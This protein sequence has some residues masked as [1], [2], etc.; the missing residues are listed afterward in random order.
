MSTLEAVPLTAVPPTSEISSEVQSFTVQPTPA[1]LTVQPAPTTEVDVLVKFSTGFKSFN[2]S[3]TPEVKAAAIKLKLAFNVR[4][5]KGGTHL[6]VNGEEM[7][8]KKFVDKYF[9]ITPKRFNQI[10]D[11]EEKKDTPLPPPPDPAKDNVA[12]DGNKFEELDQQLHAAL[13]ELERMKAD[14][15]ALVVERWSDLEPDR[16]QVELTKIIEAL[17]LGG[18]LRVEIE[19]DVQ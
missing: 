7:D 1:K 9:G 4:Q 12:L 18:Y 6:L 2:Q 11:L 16:V 19:G 17:N 5:G 3:L 10:L 14:P 13:A 8:W 15:I